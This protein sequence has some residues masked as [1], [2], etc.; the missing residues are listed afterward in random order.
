MLLFSLGVLVGC[1]TPTPTVS[2]PEETASDRRVSLTITGDLLFEQ[3]LYDAWEEYSFGDYFDLLKPYLSGDIVIGNQEVPIAGE[4]LGVSGVAFSF[5]APVQVAQQLGTVG[6]DVLTLANNHCY[7]RGYDGVVNTIAN[8]Q[9]NGIT[10]IGVF[11]DEKSS[12]EITVIEKNGVRIAIL[13]YTYGTNVPIEAKHDYVTKTFL[14]AEGVFDE[15]HRQL[16]QADVEK[17]QAQADIII[18]AMH[19]GNEFTFALSETQLQAAAYLN[20][21]GVDLIIGNH[22]H[23]LQTMD[24]LVNEEGEETLVFYS[25]GNLVSAAAMVD[26][27]S[28]A[29]A[30]LYEMGGIVNLDVVIDGESGEVRMENVVLTPVINHFDVNYKHFQ[31]IPL[32]DYTQEQAQAHCQRQYSAD[33]NKV[34]LSEQ[35]ESLFDRKI[36]VDM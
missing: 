13:A 4:Q 36:Q 27:A 19:W 7:D 23:C 31:L 32:K 34:W 20:D 21:L 5:N 26:R 1:Q 6:F 28:V 35:V 29:F 2:E 8:L 16:L 18:V 14:N 9:E 33:F 3:S 17:A 11:A 25:L 30:N 22:S 24:R 15:A 12:N 10:P